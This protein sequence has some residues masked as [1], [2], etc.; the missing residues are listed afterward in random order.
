MLI[1]I[2]RVLTIWFAMIAYAASDVLVPGAAVSVAP[3]ARPHN[4]SAAF[5]CEAHF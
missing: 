3:G 2:L 1:L 4:R 5:V